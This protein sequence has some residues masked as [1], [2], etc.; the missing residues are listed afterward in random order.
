MNPGPETRGIAVRLAGMEHVLVAPHAADDEQL[1]W[2]Q[3][4]QCLA[5]DT[6]ACERLL[7]R[8]ESRI[9]RQMWRFTRDRSVQS[10]LVQEVMVQTFLS[11]HRYRPEK[12]PM[13]HW[14]SRIA[15]R[16]GYG[17]WKQES[18]RRKHRSL[19]DLIAAPPVQS[20][21]SPEEAAKLLH[22]LLSLLLPADRL[23]LTL[24][25]FDDCTVRQIA[26]RT[27]WNTPMVKM[28]LHRARRRLRKIIEQRNL[29]ET[30]LELSHGTD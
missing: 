17:Y 3:C 7:K 20:P 28:R 24:L 9:A 1:D 8:H 13:A 10:E 12:T 2:L 26:D 4:R 27:G 21:P 11:M 30:L 29:K 14:I 19:D 22:E 25:Y 23:V 18:R 15:T 6:Q 16:V 5:G